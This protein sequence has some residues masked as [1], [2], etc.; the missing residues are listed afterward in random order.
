MWS[1]TSDALRDRI[2][3]SEKFDAAAFKRFLAERR[4]TVQQFIFNWIVEDVYCIE[5]LIELHKRTGLDMNT[6]S[7][8][9]NTLW[10]NIVLQR[11]FLPSFYPETVLKFI[12][13]TN[14]LLYASR[15]S[16]GMYNIDAAF[17][18][19]GFPREIK[20]RLTMFTVLF[21]KTGVMGRL[22]QDTR[23]AVCVFRWLLAHSEM[24]WTHALTL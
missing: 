2:A 9:G 5:L 20:V 23:V 24:M 22:M 8:R 15:K 12:T 3:S 13:E 7:N 16:D 17:M 18:R 1:V 6:R 4:F 14:F 21:A 11:P 10:C 19:R